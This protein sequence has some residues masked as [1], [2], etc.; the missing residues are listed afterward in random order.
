MPKTLPTFA[1]AAANLGDALRGKPDPLW[2]RPDPTSRLAGLEGIEPPEVPARLDALR[3]RHRREALFEHAGFWI[4]LFAAM[5]LGFTAWNGWSPPWAVPGA[6][7]AGLLAFNFGVQVR[8]RNLRRIRLLGGGP[9]QAHEAHP[10]A[11]AVT[12][13]RVLAAGASGRARD[14]SLEHLHGIEVLDRG[15]GDHLVRFLAVGKERPTVFAEATR[16][17]APSARRLVEALRGRGLRFLGA[18]AS[19]AAEVESRTVLLR[20]DA[21]AAAQ[22][23][24]ASGRCRT[25]SEAANDA[26]ARPDAA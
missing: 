14:L 10:I 19:M 24:V 6:I 3:R 15:D 26:L 18:A 23:L 11:I 12:P 22:A 9:V 21:Y 5:G 17:D 25:L 2:R 13:G 4:N 16:V 1:D 7:G 20:P 8:G